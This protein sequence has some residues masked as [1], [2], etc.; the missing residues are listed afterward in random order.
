MESYDEEDEDDDIQIRTNHPVG[1]GPSTAPPPIQTPAGVPSIPVSG[2][3][4][5][6]RISFEADETAEAVRRA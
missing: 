1:S 6:R 5:R 2:S 4:M 3:N